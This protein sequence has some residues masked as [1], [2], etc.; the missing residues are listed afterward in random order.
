MARN[1]YQT[2]RTDIGAT[3]SELR[4]AYLKLAR[5]YHP[6][7]ADEGGRANA[8]QRMQA[9]NEAWNVLGVPHKR[10]QYDAKLPVDGQANAEAHGTTMRGNAHFRAFDD[11]PIDRSD[12][13]LDPTPMAGSKPIPR[14]VTMMP[15]AM[16]AFGVTFF[17]VGLLLAAGAILAF[18]A[19]IVLLG[20]VGLL[21]MP[22]IVMS[23][24]ERD[25]LL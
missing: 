4:T 20:A 6:D 9:I 18:G 17:G 11:D 5:A 13:D 15:L 12:V 3:Q 1:H 21:M 16:L 2:L 23:R 25:P 8:E 10:R 22:L 7:Q 14:W 19:I 24:A